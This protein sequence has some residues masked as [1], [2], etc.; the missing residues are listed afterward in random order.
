MKRLYFFIRVVMPQGRR[1]ILLSGCPIKSGKQKNMTPAEVVISVLGVRPLARSLGVSPGCVTR[2]R[3]RGGFIPST[4][5]AAILRLGEGKIT[6]DDLV[7]GR[8]DSFKQQG[9]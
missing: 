6:S 4:Y 2:W 1:F 8:D 9:L 7:K 5:Y 3:T